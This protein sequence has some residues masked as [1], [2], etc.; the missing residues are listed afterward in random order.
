MNKE[1]TELL[2]GGLAI[3]ALIGGGV[4]WLDRDTCVKK[5]GTWKFP[6]GPCIGTGPG[7][8]CP[9]GQTYD[10]ATGK[11]V[12]ISTTLPQPTGF[13]IVVPA[14]ADSQTVTCTAQWNPVTEM[15]SGDYYSLVVSAN[16]NQLFSKQIPMGTTSYQ[17]SAP[18][19]SSLSGQLSACTGS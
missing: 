7:T 6:F 10:S 14:T 17:F 9:Q 12:P 4:V 8:T 13:K 15:I 1:N 19:G 18:A 16:G 11:C 2:I 3:A 5:G